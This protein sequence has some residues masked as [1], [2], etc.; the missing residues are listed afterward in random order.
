MFE[1]ALAQIT[2]TEAGPLENFI[3][4]LQEKLDGKLESG[5]APDAPTL[6]GILS[7]GADES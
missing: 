3:G 4:K 6:T 2:R 1:S 5:Y 7:F